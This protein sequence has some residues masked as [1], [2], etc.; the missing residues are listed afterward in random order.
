[1]ISGP[2]PG[3]REHIPLAQGRHP[4]RGRGGQRVCCR[5]VKPYCAQYNKV[6]YDKSPAPGAG[7]AAALRCLPYKVLIP[8]VA[9]LPGAAALGGSATDILVGSQSW[10]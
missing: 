9:A 3:A 1:M 4:P 5:S 8:A 6:L 10:R 7:L 2:T